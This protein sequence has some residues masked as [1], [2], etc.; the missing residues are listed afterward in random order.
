[1]AV[2]PDFFL[3]PRTSRLLPIAGA[4]AYDPASSALVL[5]ADPCAGNMRGS[6]A[7]FLIKETDYLTRLDYLTPIQF[8]RIQL[9]FSFIF[10]YIYLSL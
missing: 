2:P 7:A 9:L 5:T 6:C 1:M 3:H 4:V 10:S 8:D